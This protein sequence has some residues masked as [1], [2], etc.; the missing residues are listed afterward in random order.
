MRVIR[1]VEGARSSRAAMIVSGF[2][3][4]R[5]GEADEKRLVAAT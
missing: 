4:S 3:A 1:S 2:A 5:L